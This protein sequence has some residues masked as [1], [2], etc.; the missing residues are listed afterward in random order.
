MEFRI[1]IR[2]LYY[3]IAKFALHARIRPER[4]FSN[5]QIIPPGRKGAKFGGGKRN[6][7]TDYFHYFFPALASLRE[8]FRVSVAALPR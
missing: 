1:T 7:L 3:Y 5:S 8:I 4:K 2:R 6:I